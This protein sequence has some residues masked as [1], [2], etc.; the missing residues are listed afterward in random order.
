MRDLRTG[1]S[2]PNRSFT[3]E[4][5]VRVLGDTAFV[6]SR[7]KIRSAPTWNGLTNIYLKQQGRW[8]CIH[9][10]SPLLEKQ[11]QKQLAELAKIDLALLERTSLL[12]VKS[13]ELKEIE[14]AP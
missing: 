1:A 13:A 2:P 10:H 8:R 7:I 14:S 3:I 4:I 5:K 11:R 12:E 6:T 9:S